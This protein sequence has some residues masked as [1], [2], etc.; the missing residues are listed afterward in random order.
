MRPSTQVAPA[1][2]RLSREPALSLPKGRLARAFWSRRCFPRARPL[3]LPVVTSGIILLEAS[4]NQ[5]WDYR[6]LYLLA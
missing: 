5:H 3:P 1:S 2:R 6:H 4:C